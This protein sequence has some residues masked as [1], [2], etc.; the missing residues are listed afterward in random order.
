MPLTFQVSTLTARPP[1]H[2]SVTV[3]PSKGLMH[4]A[5]TSAIFCFVEDPLKFHNVSQNVLIDNN[6]NYV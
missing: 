4:L 5:T 2:F 6:S 1:R 3:P